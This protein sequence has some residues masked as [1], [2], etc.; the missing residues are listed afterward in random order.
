MSAQQKTSE[1]SKIHS[2]S[3]T[4]DKNGD[5]TGK[6]ILRIYNKIIYAGNI[7]NGEPHDDKAWVLMLNISDEF[8]GYVGFVGEFVH[9]LPYGPCNIYPE[10]NN[11]DSKIEGMM[12]AGKFVR[13]AYEG[14]KMHFSDVTDC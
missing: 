9:G 8:T 5:P 12:I 7:E 4:F 6:G 14:S 1:N 10:V 13:P 3:G 2:W 11:P